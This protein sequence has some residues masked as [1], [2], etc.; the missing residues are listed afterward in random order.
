MK[1]II[2]GIGLCIF[3]LVSCE[4][5]IEMDMAQ[6]ADNAV[7]T[8]VLLF[9][10]QEEE[11]KLQEYYEYG[12]TT[13]GVRRIF[14]ASGSLVDEISASVTVNVPS[15]VDLN[16]IGLVIRHKAVYVVPLNGAPIAGYLADFTNGPY[17]YRLISADGTE[18][19]WII[20]FVLN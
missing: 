3:F 6:W 15:T 4:P 20:N 14:V 12:E 19:D 2:I 16:N 13:T 9:T 11:H 17:T 5:R 18:R 1:N 10:L 7:I 8:D